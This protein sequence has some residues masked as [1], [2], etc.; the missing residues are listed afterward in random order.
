MK[1]SKRY[2]ALLLSLAL[3]LAALTGCGKGRE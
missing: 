1:Q 3:L 2:L